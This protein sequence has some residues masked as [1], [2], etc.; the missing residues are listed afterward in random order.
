MSKIKKI[1]VGIILALTI[2]FIILTGFVFCSDEISSAVKIAF[3]FLGVSVVVNCV[4]SLVL[5]LKS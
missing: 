4:S 5:A 3:V 2:A 1:F